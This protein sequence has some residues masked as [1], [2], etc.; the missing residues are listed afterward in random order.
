MKPPAPQTKAF[1]AGEFKDI[2]F[3][4]VRCYLL[5]ILK[6]TALRVN[7]VHPIDFVGGATFK[8]PAQAP[9]GQV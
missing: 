5:S 1:L 2:V 8:P 4:P 7:E 6:A 3:T 9:Y